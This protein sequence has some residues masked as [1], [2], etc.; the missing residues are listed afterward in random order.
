MVEHKTT[1]YCQTFFEVSQAILSSLSLKDILNSLVKMTVGVLGVKAGSLRLVNEKTNLL[2][3]VASHLLSKKYLDKGPLSSDQSIPEVLEG[4]VA[5]IKDAFKDPRIQYK[6]EKMEEGINTILSVPVVAR[7]KVIGVLRL[8][9]AQPR[10][11]SNEEIEFVSALAEMGGLA[12][13]NAKIY[14]DEDVKL[15]SLLK[16][17]GIEFPKEAKR[18]KQKFKSFALE[19]IDS[20]KSLEYFR[21]LHEITRA[22][23]STLDSQQVMDLVTEKVLEIMKVKACSLFFVNETTRELQLVAS[24]G[25]SEHYLKKGPIRVDKSI[26]KTLDGIPVLILDATTDQRVE[27]PSENARE[28]IASILSVPIIARE[29]VIGVLR[30]YSQ[31]TRQYSQ[32][33][34]TFFSALAAIAGVA[35]MNAKLYEKTQ[36]DLSFWKATLGYLDVRGDQS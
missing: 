29:R 5:I 7:D 3:L 26:R 20:S 24:R 23:L 30:L 22:I 9:S 18:S 2:E 35:I 10:D 11:F 16:E 31:E 4:K 15:D 13:A 27:Y 1:K 14:E 21:L 28:G 8:Y 6:S 34:V 33:E 12:I 19:P 25:L 17:V 32:V 36:Y